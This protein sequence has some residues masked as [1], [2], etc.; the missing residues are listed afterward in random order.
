M[1]RVAVTG[2][3]G[4]MGQEVIALAHERDDVELAFAVSRDPEDVAVD[5]M[6][7]ADEQLPALLAEHDPDVLVDFTVPESSVEYVSACAAAGVAVVVGTTG[8]SEE[9]YATLEIASESVPVLESSNF[10]RGIQALLNVVDE[11]VSALPD[12]DIELVE[13]HH[14]AKRDAPSGTANMILDRIDEQRDLNRVYGR[15]GEAPR[16]EDEVGV[17]VRRAG[18]IR[19]EHEVLLAGNDEVVTLTHRAE[20]RGVFAAGALDAAVWVA[21]RDAGWY[22]FADVIGDSQ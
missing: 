15:E 21:A 9:Q 18:N 5:V 1:T 17:L 8:F 2:A 20:S 19:G 22:D 10:A 7:D 16:S 4:R 11:A 14:N 6:L 13:T 12:Y 3:T